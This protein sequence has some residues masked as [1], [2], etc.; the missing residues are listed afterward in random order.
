MRTIALDIHKRFAEVAVHEGGEVRRMGRIGTSVRELRALADSL[1]K[2]DH[3]VVESTA[4]T[5][6]LV[7]LLSEHAGKVTV[8]NPMRTQA[9]ASAKVKTDK[10]DARVLAQLGAADFIPEVWAPDRETL[11]LRRRIAHRA[12]LVRQRTRLRNQIHAVLARNFVEVPVTDVFGKR[13]RQFLARVE[14][15]EFERAQLDSALRLHDALEAEVVTAERSLAKEALGRPDVRRLMTIPGVGSIT[16]LAIVSVIGDVHRFPSAR[17]LVGYLGLDP[18]VRQSGDRGARTGR[19][20][21]QGQAHA[22]GLLIEAAHSATKVPGPLRAFCGRIQARRGR[23]VALVA[24]ARKLTVIAWHLLSKQEDYRFGS[25]SLTRRKLRDLQNRAG[26][27]GARVRY[28]S[29]RE[30]K[31]DRRLLE[32]AERDYALEVAR[33]SDGAGAANGDATLKGPRG[34]NDARQA[35][36]PRKPALLVG[37]HPRQEE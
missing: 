28:A 11:A 13:G 7:E 12:S 32:Q 20:S 31:V 19:I 14:L 36:C 3:V 30:K 1:E 6:A 34:A 17:H 4:F 5:W 23:Q 26:A 25:E 8:S 9:I 24:T 33:R 10:V 22:R 2:T 35:R 16:A 15:D 37:D 29:E 21:R 27:S 18:R